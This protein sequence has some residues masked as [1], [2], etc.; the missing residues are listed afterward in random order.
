MSVPFQSCWP[1]GCQ[2]PT[3]RRTNGVAVASAADFGAIGDP[4]SYLG[5]VDPLPPARPGQV[6]PANAAPHL[7]VR[8]KGV[9]GPW[10]CGSAVGLQRS[11]RTFWGEEVP[12]DHF[13]GP[14]QQARPHFGVPDALY[15]ALVETVEPALSARVVRIDTMAGTLTLQPAPT[16]RA[17]QIAAALGGQNVWVTPDD[18][19]PIQDALYAVQ[20][21]MIAQGLAA[22]EVDLPVGTFQLGVS[23]AEPEANKPLLLPSGIT[24][25]GAGKALTTLLMAPQI[26]QT[27]LDW[28]TEEEVLRRSGRSL[29]AY[30]SNRLVCLMNQYST[31]LPYNIVYPYL[32]Q[33][34]SPGQEGTPLKKR[35]YGIAVADLTVDMNKENQAL[36]YTG[37]GN[38][39]L[40]DGK[41]QDSLS[42]TISAPYPDPS[43]AD[44]K[45]RLNWRS[46]FPFPGHYSFVVSVATGG[47]PDDESTV[48]A[49]PQGD[50]A[51]NVASSNNG[52]G[53]VL[54]KLPFDIAKLAHV[55][56]Y[57]QWSEEVSQAQGP[58]FNLKFPI[59]GYEY[60]WPI[61]YRKYEVSP[62]QIKPFGEGIY[63]HFNVQGDPGNLGPL[64]APDGGDFWIPP[65][66]GWTGQPLSGSGMSDG[67]ALSNAS[68]CTISRVKI[69]GAPVAGIRLGANVLDLTGEGGTVDHMT[70]EDTDFDDI[71][72]AGIVVTWLA[73]T[74]DLRRCAFTRMG[75]TGLKFDDSTKAG[76]QSNITLTDC[77]FWDCAYALYSEFISGRL[78]RNVRIIHC[79]FLE[80]LYHIYWGREGDISI[81]GG[82][83]F[84][85]SIKCAIAIAGPS[86][87]LNLSASCF[88]GN[89]APPYSSPAYYSW[90]PVSV[91]A[92]LTPADFSQVAVPANTNFSIESCDFIDFP[93]LPWFS[94][95]YDFAQGF[96]VP[97]CYNG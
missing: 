37:G 45:N 17:A 14:P 84:Q 80:S 78:S 32:P 97:P 72:H 39:N 91:V 11:V 74:I 44:P 53:L 63:F 48:V 89:V 69:V 46:D 55:Y 13:S 92:S 43:P 23:W 15:E 61:F 20:D 87:T 65:G 85:W 75:Y 52:V 86:T 88:D 21:A 19:R 31:A 22:G 4:L 27:V 49:T 6:A 40:W 70:I 42:P 67:I 76:E 83:R 73:D 77:F 24:L 1:V 50:L 51:S 38:E 5:T 81:S 90:S 58:E 66:L 16:P 7:T 12:V 25:Q 29:E 3:I 34:R 57:V 33:P 8:F 35:D 94:S 2:V 28:L 60:G 54:A 59:V 62:T 64:P 71:H 79:S 9:F 30:G 93:N 95:V 82:S 36:F 10:K 18:R 68:A 41:G 96:F 26:T 56:V 47:G